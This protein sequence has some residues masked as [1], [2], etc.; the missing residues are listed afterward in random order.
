MLTTKAFITNNMLRWARERAR[1]TPSDVARH[2]HIKL[3]TYINWEQGR[4]KPTFAQTFRM[5]NLFQI[6]LGYFFLDTPPEIQPSI[7]DLRTLATAGSPVTISL[8]LSDLLAEI[9][10][11]QD[12]YR[13]YILSI[14][15]E[16]LPFVGS[17]TI[18]SEPELVASSIRS[19][20]GLDTSV[21]LKAQTIDDYIRELVRRAEAEGILVFR[22]KFVGNNPNRRLLVEEFRGFA[23]ADRFAPVIF[24][25]DNDSPS[26][27]VFTIAH[28]L[29]H[30]WLA[31][32]G[33]SNPSL[34][35]TANIPLIEQKCN[36]IAAEVLVPKAEFLSGWNIAANTGTKIERLARVFRVSVFVVLLRALDCKLLTRT[37]FDE[38]YEH[39]ED[40][41]K[42]KVDTQKKTDGG[43]FYKTLFKR[44]SRRF[45]ETAVEA[46][47][48]GRERTIEVA[49]LLA[50][51]PSIIPKLWCKMTKKPYA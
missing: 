3:D 37:E 6:P 8:E 46:A 34:R 40:N 43:D 1:L 44:H 21:R 48:T 5:A 13:D 41:L 14:G 22:S 2:L 29:A 38:L 25:N 36:T 30:I 49:R 33:I 50:V 17:F 39:Y 35:H 31:V 42:L 32:S 11:K 18:N 9:Q 47:M 51:R 16:A 27:Q 24:I 26:A 12:W 28:E 10:L 15:G 4:T 7:P 19:R 45:I 23:I 20:L